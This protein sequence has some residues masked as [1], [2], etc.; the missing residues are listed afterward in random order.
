MDPPRGSIVVVDPAFPHTEK[1]IQITGTKPSNGSSGVASFTGVLTGVQ[2]DGTYCFTAVIVVPSGSD[3]CSLSFMNGA[4]EEFLHVDFLPDN[5]ARVDD[6]TEFGSFARDQVFQV[7]VILKVGPQST[8]LITLSGGASGQINYTV[9]PPFQPLAR[10]FGAIQLWKGF[11]N[12]G[13]FLATDILVTR[14]G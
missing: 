9:L 11:G 4:F 3:V 1:W 5:R 6:I 7:Q 14:V 8:A 2:G 12:T 13:S 10:Q